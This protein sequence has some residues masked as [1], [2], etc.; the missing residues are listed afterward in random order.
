MIEGVPQDC[1]VFDAPDSTVHAYIIEEYGSGLDGYRLTEGQWEM[2][3]G[4]G[5]VLNYRDD[6][7]FVRHQ[8]NQLRPDGTAYGD[9]Q[10]LLISFR[11]C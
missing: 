6:A 9:A 2:I 10:G 3:I 4:G 7:R 1:I 5:D 11:S 8:A